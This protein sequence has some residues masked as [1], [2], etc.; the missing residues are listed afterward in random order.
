R[1][2][3]AGG[4]GGAPAARGLLGRAAAGGQ[5]EGER[6]GEGDRRPAPAR[7][8][9]RG[10]W[11]HWARV[12]SSGVAGAAGAG[13]VVAAQVGVAGVAARR[14]PTARPMAALALG[15]MTLAM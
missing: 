11:L 4:G 1:F 12:L 7:P 3:A 15:A 14:R 9:G 2:G 5:D 6:D 13:R 8:S 10:R